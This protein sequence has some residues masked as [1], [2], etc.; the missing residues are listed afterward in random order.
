ML[1]GVCVSVGQRDKGWIGRPGGDLLSRAL[2]HSTMGA[3]AFHVRVR[4]GIGCR[5]PA[6]ATRSSNQPTHDVCG[7]VGVGSGFLCVCECVDDCC[8]WGVTL[9]L[10][11]D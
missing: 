1:C 6:I 11:G 7:F 4:D 2:R 8:A 9:S 10:S 3:G 5:F